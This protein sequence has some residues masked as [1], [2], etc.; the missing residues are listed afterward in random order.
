MVEKTQKIKAFL[1]ERGISGIE[2]VRRYEKGAV[3]KT[4]LVQTVSGSYTFRIYSTRSKSSIEA[5]I[6]LLSCL[7]KLPVP[8]PIFLGDEKIFSFDGKW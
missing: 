2:E 3:N 7:E 5:D 8:H 6:K 4:Y 1:E